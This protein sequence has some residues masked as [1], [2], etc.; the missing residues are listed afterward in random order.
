MVCF[1]W[2]FLWNPF[3]E[4]GRQLRIKWVLQEWAEEDK[5]VCHKEKRRASLA[6]ESEKKQTLLRLHIG[7]WCFFWNHCKQQK[8]IKKQRLEFPSLQFV[9]RQRVNQQRGA[10]SSESGTLI[11]WPCRGVANDPWW[12]SQPGRCIQVPSFKNSRTWDTP[13]SQKWSINQQCRRNK[14]QQSRSLPRSKMTYYG[15]VFNGHRC[16]L[17]QTVFDIV[18]ELNK[19]RERK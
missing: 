12:T 10:R 16:H 11:L 17:D 19:R 7:S 8:S 13:E 15:I 2:F 18:R 3:V 1:N 6:N 4:S 5:A 14:D 9:R